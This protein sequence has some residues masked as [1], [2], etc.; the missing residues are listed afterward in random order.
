MAKKLT[1][2]TAMIY[3]EAGE[4]LAESK[5]WGHNPEDNSI[6]L[7][8]VPGLEEEI[9]YDLLIPMAP[10]PY[11]CKGKI[12]IRNGIKHM[13]LF[14]VKDSD[15]RKE[16]RFS[17]NVAAEIEFLI[18]DNQSYPTHHPVEVYLK[19]LSKNGLCFR[20]VKNTLSVGD[21]ISMRLAL[22]EKSN[23]LLTALVVHRKD[24]D[25]YVSEYGCRLMKKG[26]V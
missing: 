14:K 4:E 24:V 13:R 5:I 26:K 16:P 21:S 19:N 11:I 3:N 9:I 25:D 17:V 20:A 10:M 6:E 23:K 12:Q 22:N 7:S 8:E 2:Y 18:Y 15:N 1:G